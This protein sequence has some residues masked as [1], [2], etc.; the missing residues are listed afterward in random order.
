[1]SGHK[2]K[3]MSRTLK[4]QRE[5]VEYLAMR[6][7][8]AANKALMLEDYEDGDTRTDSYT[9][10]PEWIAARA[11]MRGLM[12]QEGVERCRW[13]RMVKATYESA[14]NMQLQPLPWTGEEF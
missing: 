5:L 7:R 14:D 2:E 8:Q 9:D 3:K 6:A 10:K 1:V 12:N 11:E 4:Q 13:E